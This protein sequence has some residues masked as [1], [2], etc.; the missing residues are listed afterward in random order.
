MKRFLM[1]KKNAVITALV[2]T[3]VAVAL[4]AAGGALADGSVIAIEHQ[5]HGK[6][7]RFTIDY[8]VYDSYPPLCS[9]DQF[10]NYTNPDCDK[11]DSKSAN[12]NVRMTALR[13]VDCDHTATKGFPYHSPVRCKAV[14][15]GLLPTGDGTDTGALTGIDGTGGVAHW[16]AHEVPPFAYTTCRRAFGQVSVTITWRVT[17]KAWDPV[18]WNRFYTMGQTFKLKRTCH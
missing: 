10:G 12:V 8:D 7:V 16:T 18:A 3:A 15:R 9:V 6:D 11:Y 5:V 13:R 4:I 1:K 14:R 17:A 2:A